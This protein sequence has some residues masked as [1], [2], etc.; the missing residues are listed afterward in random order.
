MIVMLV[1]GMLLRCVRLSIDPPNYQLRTRMEPV[2]A[3][4]GCKVKISEH[5]THTTRRPQIERTEPVA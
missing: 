2:P 1:A 4:S 5:R 3:P